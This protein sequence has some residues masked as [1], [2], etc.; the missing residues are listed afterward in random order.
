MVREMILPDTHISVLL[1]LMKRW[2]RG[3]PTTSDEIAKETGL[4]IGH[5]NK[6]LRELR[7]EGLITSFKPVGIGYGALSVS[8]KKLVHRPSKEVSE[9]LKER[10][11]I[12]DYAKRV[13]IANDLGELK[14][15]LQG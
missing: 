13:G 15:W 8:R 5:V 6:I 9:I 2:V 4:T 12:L 11:E 14:R 7:A 3:E 1:V 10:S